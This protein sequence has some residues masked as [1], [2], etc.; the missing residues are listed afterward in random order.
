MPFTLRAAAA[1]A[2]LCTMLALTGC[3]GSK[4]ASNSGAPSVA[5]TDT[6]TQAA[7]N[8]PAP[9]DQT[10][11]GCPPEGDGGDHALNVRKNRIDTGAW[12]VAT[13][14]D[15]VNLAYPQTV[16]KKARATWSDS[17]AAA[18]A[19]YEGRPVQVEGYLLMVRH[20]GTES[21]NCH[22]P[23]AR[24][25]HMWLGSSPG[26]SADRAT[27]MIV[28]VTPR[29]RALHSSWQSDTQLLHLAHKHVRISGWLLL[30]QEHPEQLGKTRGTLWE[31][32]PVM[33][34]DVE[35]NSH[36]TSF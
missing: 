16:A 14:K 36:W 8:W 1:S 7:G 17:D 34:I 3:G 4:T 32:H 23:N 30:D 19:Q 31:I 18:V 6:T 9:V 2:V 25:F 20:E 15:L 24:D 26:T 11:Q 27:S 29:S 35:Q 5:A 28:E 33:A 13:V 22:D 21:P 10:F 12:Q